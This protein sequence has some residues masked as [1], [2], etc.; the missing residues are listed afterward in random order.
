MFRSLRV[1]MAIVALCA[2]SACSDASYS[3]ASFAPG[4]YWAPPDRSGALGLV[5]SPFRGV[6]STGS[7][8][9][10]PPPVPGSPPTA[11]R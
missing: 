11:F 6:P 7:E 3:R 1:S 5:E 2:A 9:T 4:N 10:S 8:L